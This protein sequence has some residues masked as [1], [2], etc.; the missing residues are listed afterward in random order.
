MPTNEDF[1]KCTYLSDKGYKLWGNKRFNSFDFYL[2]RRFGT[3]VAKISLNGGFT[4]P[5]RDGTLSSK[6]CL[7]CSENGAGDFCATSPTISSQMLE[8]TQKSFEYSTSNKWSQVK[9]YISL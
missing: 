5:N 6:G 1:Y 3:K 7:F 8:A 9:K 4:C 2:K